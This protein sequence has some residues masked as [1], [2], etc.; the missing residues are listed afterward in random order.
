MPFNSDNANINHYPGTSK[1]DVERG[2][3]IVSQE[4]AFDASWETNNSGRREGR[5]FPTEGD[6]V[7]NSD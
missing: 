7:G 6:V 5:T 3:G 1:E 2:Y 4:D